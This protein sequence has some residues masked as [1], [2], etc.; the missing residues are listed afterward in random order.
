MTRRE[1]LAAAAVVPVAA[2]AADAAMI[3]VVDTHQH[4]WDLEKFK[5]PWIKPGSGPP[6]EGQHTPKEYAEVTKGLNVVKAVYMEV[7]MVRG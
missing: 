1:F 5:L 6:L 4:L 3:P 2:R 7:G